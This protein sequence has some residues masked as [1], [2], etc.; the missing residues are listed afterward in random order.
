MYNVIDVQDHQAHNSVPCSQVQPMRAS[1]RQAC[2]LQEHYAFE[3]TYYSFQQ[4]FYFSPIT[5]KIIPWMMP[6]RHNYMDFLIKSKHK[7]FL[8]GSRY[9]NRV[10]T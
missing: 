8:K 6:E 4:F 2:I 1:D 9:S 3:I 5:L 7:T 10:A